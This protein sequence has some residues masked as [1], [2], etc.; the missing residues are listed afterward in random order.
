MNHQQYN[1]DYSTQESLHFR[2]GDDVWPRVYLVT[3]YAQGHEPIFNIPA[4]HALLEETWKAIPERFPGLI[5]DACVIEP[6]HIRFILHLADHEG[7]T[8]TLGR[9]VGTY[10]SLTAIAWLRF[11]DTKEISATGLPSHIWQRNY[12]KRTICNSLELEQIKR[13]FSL[14]L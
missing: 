8:T 12:E 9:V 1:P 14:I 10:K 4:L 6:D 5:A 3:I 11:I 7:K 13:S 2:G